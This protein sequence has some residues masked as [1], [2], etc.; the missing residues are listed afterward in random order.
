[1][2]VPLPPAGATLLISDGNEASSRLKATKKATMPTTSIHR[3]LPN[4]QKNSSHS[5]SAQTAP[6]STRRI[7]RFFS[8]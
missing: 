3:P 4:H 2:A 1:M 6:S 7:W 5:S 8:P